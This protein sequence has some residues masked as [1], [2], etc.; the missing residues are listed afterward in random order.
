MDEAFYDPVLCFK[1]LATTDL[2]T[3]F[4]EHIKHKHSTATSRQTQLSININ[5]N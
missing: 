3:Q 5:L 2:F 1:H 4:V